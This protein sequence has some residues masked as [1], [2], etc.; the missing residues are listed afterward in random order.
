T[1]QLFLDDGPEVV[2]VALLEH[3]FAPQQRQQS[4]EVACIA[5]Q[6]AVEIEAHG[7][8]DTRC[9]RHISSF[10]HFM[11]RNPDPRTLRGMLADAVSQTLIEDEHPNASADELLAPLNDEQRAAVRHFEGPALV[12]AG[13]GSGKTRTVV[14]RIAYLLREHGVLPQQV[15]AVTFTNKAAGELRERV[16]SL[17][18][19]PGR[20]LWVSTFHSACL[21]VLRMYGERIDLKQGFGIYD[22]GDQLDVLKDLLGTTPGMVDVSPRTIRSLIDRAKSNLW[23]PQQFHE[24]GEKAWGRIVVGLPLESVVDVY[25]LY[26]ARLK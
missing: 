4:S 16:E 22:D 5:A 23:T 18:G 14:H 24:E 1:A 3:D 21:R 2:H 11:K 8:D 6:S 25:A 17:I 13:A 15:L 7:F 19:T 26:Q 10:V 9:R 20:D 12:L